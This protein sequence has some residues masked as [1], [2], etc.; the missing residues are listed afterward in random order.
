MRE[1]RAQDTQLSEIHRFEHRF[2]RHSKGACFF[3]TAN[4]VI[5]FHSA[6]I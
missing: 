3:R 2:R 6:I 1:K 4:I 5:F